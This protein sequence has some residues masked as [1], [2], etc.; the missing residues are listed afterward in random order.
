MLAEM[1]KKRQEQE[2]EEK[3]KKVIA[4]FDGI[5]SLDNV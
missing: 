3:R 2:E 1:E 4:G 5:L